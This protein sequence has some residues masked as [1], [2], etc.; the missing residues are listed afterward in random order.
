MYMATERLTR[1]LSGVKGIF[2]ADNSQTCLRGDEVRRVLEASGATRGLKRITVP[3]SFTTDQ[4]KSMR[5][6]SGGEDFTSEDP[7]HDATLKGL[8]EFLLLLSTLDACAQNARAKLLWEA[9]HE[10]EIRYGPGVFS[11]TYSWFY[12]HRRSAEFDAAFVKR[13]RE[14]RWVPDIDGTMRRPEFVSFEALGWR[15]IH[16]SSRLYAST[17]RN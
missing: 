8:E 4:K 1:L 15:G 17:S 14:A 12:Y 9:L 16:F 7:I 5:I 13:L 10:L 3:A 11:C 6:E 2:F